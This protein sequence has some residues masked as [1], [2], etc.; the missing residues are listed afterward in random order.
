MEKADYVELKMFS[1][2]HL[3]VLHSFELPEEQEQFTA[4]PSEMLEVAEGQHRIVIVSDHEPVVP[5]NLVY[6]K[7]LISRLSVEF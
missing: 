5:L 1:D 3:E 4:L 6:K 7:N 2:E